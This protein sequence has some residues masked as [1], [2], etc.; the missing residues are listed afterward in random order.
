MDVKV[1]ANGG[2]KQIKIISFSPDIFILHLLIPQGVST[3]RLFINPAGLKPL[4]VH[5]P[6]MWL[7]DGDR[8]CSNPMWYVR[9]RL[10]V[11]QQKQLFGSLD[12]QFLNLRWEKGSTLHCYFWGV[13]LA[14]ILF[15]GIQDSSFTLSVVIIQWN[16]SFYSSN[17]M[18]LCLFFMNH[19]CSGTI[20]HYINMGSQHFLTT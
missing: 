15:Y 3:I 16:P 9:G 4:G 14:S 13:F 19:L 8:N 2:K 12:G 6:L 11:L 5:C 7:W 17:D 10:L 1:I 20:M 18:H